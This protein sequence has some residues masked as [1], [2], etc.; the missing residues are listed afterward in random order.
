MRGRPRGK[1]LR[2]L[3]VATL[4]P[5]VAALAVFGVLAHEVARRSLEDELGRRLATAAA[6]A[7][8]TIL[9]EQVRA[10]GEEAGSR[11][12]RGDGSLTHANVGRK[13]QAVRQQ[14]GVRRVALVTQDLVGRMDTEGAIPHGALAHEIR[15]DAA[16]LARAVSGIPSASPLFKGHDGRLYK[17]GYAAIGAGPNVAGFVV[18]EGSADSFAALAAFRR[19]LM[20]GGLAAL[21]AVVAVT[22]MVARRMTGPLG[23][24][25]GAAER[26]GRGEL[27]SPVSIETHDELGLLA[28][29]M[30]EMRSAL[31]AR[32]ERLQMM[33]A[34]IAHEVRNPLGGLELYAGLL[35]EALAGQPERLAE[36]ASIE[37]EV[38]YLSAAVAEFLAYARRPPPEIG[39]VPVRALLEEVRELCLSAPVEEARGPIVSVEAD[40]GADVAVSG[41]RGQ[42]RRT[43]LNLARNGVA[44]AASQPAAGTSGR[45][46]MAATRRGNT[47][48]IQV[49]DNGPGVPVDLRHRIFAPFFT[50]REKGT[51]LGLAFVQEIV[52]D[53]GSEIHV[54]DA[55]GGGARFSFSLDVVGN[56]GARN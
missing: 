9:P 19:W 55:P 30:D 22:I 18:V 31:R 25:A 51:G 12:G 4:L 1:L 37:R 17:R 45:V 3:L 35:R 29:T 27:D 21:A 39:S 10:L 24:L 42:L 14:L 50:T 33:L 41:D 56:E 46:V 7:A 5:T 49:R 54:D 52:R 34:G 11:D 38:R 28:S 23:R 13:L 15:G 20:A 48:E 36:V 26:I 2:K 32:D 16:E 47:V 53:H 40:A 8:L 43:L 6:G 44:A